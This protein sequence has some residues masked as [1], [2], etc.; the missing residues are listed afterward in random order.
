MGNQV[1][2]IKQQAAMHSRSRYG[3]S[4]VMSRSRLLRPR[5]VGEQRSYLQENIPS[6]DYG[7]GKGR[8]SILWLYQTG[9]VTPSVSNTMNDY[10]KRRYSMV[11][12]QQ[13]VIG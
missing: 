8:V 11:K 13:R 1:L 2:Q 10:M 4:S 9:F 6:T 5:A 12:A 7:S 3:A